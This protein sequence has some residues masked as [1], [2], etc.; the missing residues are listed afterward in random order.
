MSR[1]SL[2]EKVGQLLVPRVP[3]VADKATRKRLKE[4]VRKYKIGGLLFGKGT[5]DGQAAL[6]NQ[7]QKDA[8]VPLLM[9][10]DGEW[11][12]AM[13]LSDA[14]S[15][16]RNA[17]LGCIKDDALIEA[18]GREVGRELRQL[19]VHVNF[20]PVADANTN[21]LNPV[22]NI[23]SFGEDPRRV[24]AKVVAYSRGLESEGVLSVAKHF[25]GHGDTDTDSHKARLSPSCG[26]TASAWTAWSCFL[27]ASISAQVWVA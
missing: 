8:K 25:P 1:L 15:F 20:A 10:V 23:R 12:L 27:S 2:Q 22:I 4:W 5:I 11:G 3:A 18:Y 24:A 19:G 14:P 26:T 9:T 16:P 13:R 21:P 6:T 7:A 17:A